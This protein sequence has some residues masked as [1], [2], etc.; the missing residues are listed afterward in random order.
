MKDEG[1]PGDIWLV[2]VAASL[3]S[4]HPAITILSPEN[5]TYTANDIPLI[6]TVD[7]PIPWM[8]YSLDGQNPVTIA[9][10]TSLHRLSE[11]PHNLIVYVKDTLGNLEPPKLF[12]SGAF[13]IAYREFVLSKYRTIN[14][15][16]RR[17]SVSK[18]SVNLNC[19]EVS[20]ISL[21]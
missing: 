7:K 2:K 4:K 13:L 20:A 8:A 21:F 9:G 11:G 19:L 12:T 5:K 10:N 15:K 6:F 17:F 16:L 1:R 3:D 14:L 18:Y